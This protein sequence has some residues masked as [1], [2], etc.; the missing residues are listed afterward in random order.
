MKPLRANSRGDHAFTMVEI[1]ICLAIIGFA[2]VGLIGIMP[3]GTRVQKDNREETIVDQDAKYFMQA[4]SGGMRYIPNLM[5]YVD[6]TN[7]I[8]PANL[9]NELFWSF[10]ASVGS[11]TTEVR[12]VSGPIPGKGFGGNAAVAN[13]LADVSF[14]YLLTV[15]VEPF[16]GTMDTSNTS[17][18]YLSYLSNSL[19]EVRMRFEWPVLPNGK[20]APQAGGVSPKIYRFL[21]SG[22]TQEYGGYLYLH[23]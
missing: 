20:Y 17:Y 11:K 18:D 4:L 23:P 3:T 19:Y 5:R 16:S 10:L 7:G 1:A 22:S 15:D 13:N 8:S 9:T 21:V 12:S 14:K 6:R 2:L